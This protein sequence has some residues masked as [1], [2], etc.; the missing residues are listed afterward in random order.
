MRKG[1]G[2]SME[3]LFR[4]RE[5]ENRPLTG[6]L[7]TEKGGE[8]GIIAVLTL[9]REGGKRRTA[10]PSRSRE[11]VA[12]QIC[13]SSSLIRREGRGLS[14][15]ILSHRNWGERRTIDLLF[16]FIKTS[17]GREVFL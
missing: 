2:E 5:K 11:K 12:K 10:T 8:E 4:T 17:K 1:G 6:P 9:S 16:S 7:L 15:L 3:G 14:A 13:G